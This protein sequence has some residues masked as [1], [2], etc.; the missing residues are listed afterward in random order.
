MRGGA[1]IVAS[2]VRDRTL[3]R[4]QLAFFAF[5]AA[6]YG[7]WVAILV[8]AY[9][10]GGAPAAGLA[11]AIQ[12]VPACLVAP[13]GAFAG[14][15]FR[16]ERVLFG[17]YVTE[18][19]ACGIV[20]A[21][22]LV[23]ASFAV[24][25]AFATVAA[26]A[27]TFTRP[28]QS[29]FLPQVA[30]TPEKLT[31]VNA[32]ASFVESAG[33]VVGPFVAGLL[34]AVG[35][36][37]NVFA[38]FAVVLLVAAGLVA[39][40]RVSDEEAGPSEPMRPRDVARESLGGFEF[41]LRQRQ[42]G[43][44]VLALAAAVIVS[45]A[46]GVLFVAVAISL[47][48][49]G[50]DWA[51]FLGSASGLGALIGSILAFSLI[52]RRRL[53]PSLAGGMFVFGG[54]IAA[55]GFGPL[56]ATAPVFFAVSGAGES[57]AWVAGET[58]LQR[59][60]PDEMLARVFGIVEGLGLL[61]IAIGSLLASGLISAVGVR[62]ALLVIGAVAPLMTFA[63]WFPLTALDR[64]AHAPDA[65]TLAFLRGMPIFAPLPAP[66]LERIVANL[67][68]V[69]ISAG[70]TL[71]RQHEPGDRFFMIREGA[72]EVTRNGS[73][74][75]DLGPGDQFGEIALLHDVPR[76]ATVTATT[77]MKLFAL[78]REP[79]LEAVTG[80][81]QSHSRAAAM[82]RERMAHEPGDD[83]PGEGAGP[84]DARAED[85]RGPSA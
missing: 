68:A 42:A 20:A 65:E 70:A 46:L 50:Q 43:A 52:G 48:D 41:L 57:V 37:G 26:M 13:F 72:A 19:L 12:L 16:R 33:I 64:Q 85:P 58:L 25:I 53:A 24:V 30:G 39:R 40:L 4:I 61:A 23:H 17:A 49:K 10:H 14:D 54:A 1:G 27:Y 66:T 62:G 63:L 67:Q 83:S 84:V 44:L 74:L 28:T 36:P 8:Y 51:G 56:A 73:H 77:T 3:V 55:V 6:E 31:A 11:A 79:F 32:V 21:A 69:E 47:L 22:L 82:A 18:A 7:T 15:R 29:A 75:G 78:D 34:L 60:A 5:S 45:G 38:V 59:S 81:P 2:V 80:H 9:D 35:S 76:T 71:I